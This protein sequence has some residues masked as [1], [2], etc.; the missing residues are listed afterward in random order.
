MQ[1]FFTVEAPKKVSAG[2]ASLS[3]SQPLHG[4]MLIL[5]PGLT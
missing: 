4:L 3:Y 5:L 2:V 1:P